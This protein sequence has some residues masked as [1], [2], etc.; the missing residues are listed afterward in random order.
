[1]LA[2]LPTHTALACAKALNS[3]FR[4]EQPFNQGAPQGYYRVNNQ[5]LLMMGPQAT[6]SAGLAIVHYKEDLR[7]A[8]NLA[9]QAEKFAKTAG[10]NA[11]AMTAARRSGERPTVLALWEDLDWMQ[12]WVGL[13]Q[14][15]SAKGQR[16]SPLSNAWTYHLRETLPVMGKW[17]LPMMKSEIKRQLNRLENPERLKSWF[18]S[19]NIAGEDVGSQMAEWFELYEQRFKTHLDKRQDKTPDDLQDF[20]TRLL[21]RFVLTCQTLAF[22]ARGR[23]E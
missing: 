22:L 3:A 19:K 15:A 12:E 8:L 5:D 20:D 14:P 17:S 4:G 18:E 2:L 21:D 13:F 9:R 11:I 23:E 16:F 6:L 1:M 10:R 7:L